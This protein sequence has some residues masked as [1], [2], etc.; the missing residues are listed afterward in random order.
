MTTTTTETPFCQEYFWIKDF[1]VKW[2]LSLPAATDRIHMMEEIGLKPLGG[3]RPK[4]RRSDVERYETLIKRP[5]EASVENPG[6]N[7]RQA[8]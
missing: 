8:R 1:A 6:T 7:K 3:G 2:G 5:G 4:Y